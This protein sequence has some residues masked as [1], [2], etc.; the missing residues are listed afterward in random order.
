MVEA[1]L[2]FPI[3]SI[4]AVAHMAGIT[5]PT[6]RAW[7]KRYSIL[8][9]QRTESGHRRYTRRDI[10]RV[11]WLKRR[12]QEGMSISQASTLL[13]TQSAE[14]LLDSMEQELKASSNGTSVKTNGRRLNSNSNT[15]LIESPKANEIR[16]IPV[17][18]NELLEYLL[19]FNEM[20][21]DQLLAEAMGLYS[22]EAV[23]IDIIRPVLVEV[24]E[25]WLRNEVTIATEHFASNICRTRLNA[26]IDSLPL[27]KDGPLV[28]TACGPSEFHELGIVT[29]TLFLRRHGRRVIYLG[30]NV[31]AL[32]F[33]KDLRRLKPSLVAFS[34]SRTETALVL[35]HEI[36]PV[37]EQVRT[38]N[39]PSLI[40]A[41]AGRAFIE[42]PSL[43]DLFSG[44]VYFG[45]DSRQTVA[46]VDQLLPRN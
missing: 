5:E 12:L 44:Q 13:E 17:L 9:P 46:L 31:P 22:P 18:I 29:T 24:G 37:I 14:S 20:G 43:H 34:A 2:D 41:Y 45:D 35:A 1:A 33:E 27:V 3:Y 21:A 26:M 11:I 42:E 30:Q 39:L 19:D 40:F 8:T 36:L 4:K 28:L 10:Y 32:D 38:N 25:R 23:C 16:S 6:L 7:E 15:T